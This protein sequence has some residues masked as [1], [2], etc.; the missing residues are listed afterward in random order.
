MLVTCLQKRHSAEG[1]CEVRVSNM[2]Q[3]PQKTAEVR[4]GKRDCTYEEDD[5]IN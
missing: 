1:A 5:I 2:P 3:W 4:K